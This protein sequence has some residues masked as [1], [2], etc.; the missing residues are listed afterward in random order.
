[1]PINENTSV[2]DTISNPS[3]Y[4]KASVT[5]KIQ[6][7][8]LV[9]H[10]SFCLGNVL[11]YLFRAPYKGSEIQDLKKAHQYL[12]WYVEDGQYLYDMEQIKEHKFIVNIFIKDIKDRYIQDRRLAIITSILGSLRRSDTSV[13]NSLTNAAT[14]LYNYILEVESRC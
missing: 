9:R 14:N 11:K 4:D 6:P 5:I 7:I 8:D 3:H 12:L 10:L 1:M 2:S 13:A